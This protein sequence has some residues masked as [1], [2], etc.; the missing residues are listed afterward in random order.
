MWR[1]VAKLQGHVTEKRVTWSVLGPKNVGKV[2]TS[3]D[4]GTAAAM[5]SKLLIYSQLRTDDWYL[6]IECK[7]CKWLKLLVRDGLE[8]G[9][10]ERSL[11]I[12]EVLWGMEGDK[13]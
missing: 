7:I 8:G 10:L 6:L 9:V 2:Q 11:V 3:A 5:C 13:R 12:A 4:V 1:K